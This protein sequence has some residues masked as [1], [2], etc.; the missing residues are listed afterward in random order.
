M[1]GVDLGGLAA[2]FEQRASGVH[3]TLPWV[4]ARGLDAEKPG[5]FVDDD[6]VGFELQDLESAWLWRHLS[7]ARGGGHRVH[8]GRGRCR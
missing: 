6:E 8:A 4:A 7:I 5:G 1:H 2:L 3:D